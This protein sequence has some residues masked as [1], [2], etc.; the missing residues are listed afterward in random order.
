MGKVLNPS[1]LKTNLNR[2]RKL[3]LKIVFTNGCFDLIHRGH[4]EYLIKAKS[5]GDIL[6]VGLNSDSSVQKLKGADRPFIEESDRA[7]ILANIIPVDAVVIFK[8]NTPYLLIKDILPDILV[9]GGDYDLEKIIG[10]DIVKKNGGKVVT[11]PFI[12]GK[13][14]T[15]ILDKIRNSS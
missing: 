9:K 8:E 15:N 2:W 3:S 10:K 6:I 7:F 4:V 14:T 13:S 11:I 12:K 1:E 5:L